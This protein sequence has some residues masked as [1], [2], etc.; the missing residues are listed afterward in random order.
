MN[1]ARMRQLGDVLRPDGLRQLR[2]A[3]GQLRDIRGLGAAREVGIG[4]A[5]E[6]EQAPVILEIDTK[7]YGPPTVGIPL[8]AKEEGGLFGR[9]RN[10]K[11]IGEPGAL[12]VCEGTIANRR[13]PELLV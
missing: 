7:T 8:G 2:P 13:W 10:G 4:T 1:V 11:A 5:E 6:F 12:G 9:P 3:I